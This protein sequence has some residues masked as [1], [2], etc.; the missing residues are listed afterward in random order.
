MGLFS[1]LTAGVSGLSA[2]S[3]AM[4]AIA[5]NITNV[6]TVGYKN[7]D[8]DFQT[9]VTKQT[10][11]SFYTAGGVR[12]QTK[13]TFDVQGLLQT[14]SSQ[15]DIAIDG[16]GFFVV[17]EARRPTTGDEYLF[18]RAGS[19][20]QDDEGYLRNTAGFYLQ[21]WP[22]DA[23]GNVV[24]PTDST[25]SLPNQSVISND[26]LE[27]INLNRVGG[28]AA[29]TS[30]MTV[31]A[32]LPANA[33]VGDVQQLDTFFFDSLGN[34]N[35]P[36]FTFTKTAANQWDLAVEPPSG[37]AVA[38]VYDSTGAVYQSVGLLELTAIPDATESVV[39]GGN[40]YTFVN[41]ASVLGDDNIQVDGGRT[42][43]Q[44]VADLRDEVNN[45]LTGTPASISAPDV[46]ALLITGDAVNPNITV[47]PNGVSSGGSPASRQTSAFTVQ[48]RTN[49]N[50]GIVFGANGLPATF[51]IDKLSV[52]G[53]E[54]G[55]ADMNDVDIDGDGLVDVERI[56]LDLG[57]IGET[58]GMTQFG[59]DFTPTVMEQNGAPFG[60]LTGV[61]ISADGVM[62][63]LFDNGE[64]RPIYKVPVST[65]VNPNGLSARTGNV[66]NETVAAG[67]ATLR[68]AG[69]GP[70][71]EVAQNSLEASTVDIAQEF[72]DM[73]IVQRAYSAA[74]KIITTA[75][76]M[77]DEL[78][79][80][81]R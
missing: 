19:F 68:E 80:I 53:F 5:D 14:S 34:A 49:T 37:S 1:A 81:K 40:A 71:G 16:D 67:D 79:R 66:W 70:A 43:S 72:T 52:L 63:A 8:V 46:N 2:Q 76:E 12:A 17:N 47:D 27:T 15:T 51:N 29:A 59:G 13:N 21:G 61:S 20:A 48:S 74:T 58:N 77:L 4:G 10:T 33:S 38:T 50:A 25:A 30:N 23:S 7:A 44:V 57:S 69:T 45:D 56:T 64:S 62:E 36:N 11:S 3:S 54:N 41:G 31:G 78:V 75:D 28:A 65:F 24:L 22:T 39:I 6:N 42:L 18:T 32:N 26:F 35:A 55:A 9:L 60:T 73:I